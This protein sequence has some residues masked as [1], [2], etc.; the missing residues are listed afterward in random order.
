M[1]DEKVAYKGYEKMVKAGIKNVCIHKGLFAPGSR[2]SIESARL[3][4]RRRC[5][6]GRQGLAAAQFCHLSLR[7]RHVGGDPKQALAEFERTGRISGP[8][9][10]ANIPASTAST[11]STATS[12]S[13]SR[14]RW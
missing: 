8:A 7:Y 9:I 10:F 2:S 3:R 4:R 13:C 5:R 14:P 1:D 11:M 6:S 12:A